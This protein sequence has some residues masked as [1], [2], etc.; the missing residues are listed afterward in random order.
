MRATLLTPLAVLALLVGGCTSDDPDPAPPT[1]SSPTPTDPTTSPSPTQTETA[2][3]EGPKAFIRDS[4]DVMN[5]MIV[6]GKTAPFMA[7]ATDECTFCE[8]FQDTIRSVYEAGGRIESEGWQLGPLRRYGGT[9][10]R[11]EYVSDVR[12]TVAREFDADGKEVHTY[13]PQNATF[14]FSVRRSAK[15]WA[16]I[17]VV[18]RSD[19]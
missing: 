4:I 15:D 16:L 8:S 2:A 14:Y 17:D 7:L 12:V 10:K 11:P 6:T 9:S 18:R 19:G 13:A 5:E 3:A 1:S